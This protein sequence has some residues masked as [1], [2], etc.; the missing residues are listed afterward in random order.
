MVPIPL[1]RAPDAVAQTDLRVVADFLPRARVMSKARL[2][3]KKST[4]RR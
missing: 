3:V 4:R 2:F 1:E